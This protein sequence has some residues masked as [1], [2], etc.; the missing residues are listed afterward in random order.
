MEWII[1]APTPTHPPNPTQ[2]TP[3]PKIKLPNDDETKLLTIKLEKKIKL[4]NDDE[5]KLVRKLEEKKRERE[6]RL[7]IV[8][9]CN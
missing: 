6:R 2:P 8:W 9:C 1:A 3:P 5:A 4:P 7:P